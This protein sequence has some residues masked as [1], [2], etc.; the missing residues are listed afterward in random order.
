MKFLTRL[1]QFFALR[2]L[3]LYRRGKPRFY[4]H[5]TVCTFRYRNLMVSDIQCGNPPVTS[6][7]QT[8][9][10]VRCIAPSEIIHKQKEIT[11]VLVLGFDQACYAYTRYYPSSHPQVSFMGRVIRGL[12]HKVALRR[13]ILQQIENAQIL[14]FVF[15][16]SIHKVISNSPYII[17]QD[18]KF[19][20]I[21]LF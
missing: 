1:D 15:M 9:L 20:E 2:D 4:R 12:M 21:A 11:S 13:K 18:L 6:V 17:I 14:L 19:S 16:R 8:L 3:Y 7:P 5:F 10:T